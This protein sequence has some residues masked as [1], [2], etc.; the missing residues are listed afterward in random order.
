MCDLEKVGQPE[1]P[2]DCQVYLSNSRNF[3][4]NKGWPCA[5]S[6]RSDG[7]NLRKAF[8]AN[9]SFLA[10]F[11]ESRER[12]VAKA[13]STLKCLV[14]SNLSKLFEHCKNT[15]VV[16]VSYCNN[17][18]Y[19]GYSCIPRF[20]RY[21]SSWLCVSSTLTVCK[22]CQIVTFTMSQL[23]C[24]SS[25]DLR[26]AYFSILVDGPLQL[27]YEPCILFSPVFRSY[28]VKALSQ[29]HSQPWSILVAMWPP[30]AA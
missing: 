17:K 4:G 30:P 21:F 10:V 25:M 23:M 27:S 7:N 18:L 19:N 29:Y 6:S 12:R 1:W 13:P 8:G 3:S 16:S 20:L 9:L 28:T 11:A 22:L 24:F 2:P 5:P 26:E 14:H 15:V